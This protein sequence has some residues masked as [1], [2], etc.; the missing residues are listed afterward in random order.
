MGATMEEK[1]RRRQYILARVD[2]RNAALSQ[3]YVEAAALYR[4]AA[5]YAA[6]PAERDGSLRLAEEFEAA[7]VRHGQAVPA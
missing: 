1:R 4:K 2:A 6:F 7:A 5:E 3:R